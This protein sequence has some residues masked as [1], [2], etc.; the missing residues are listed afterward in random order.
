MK[1]IDEFILANPASLFVL[2]LIVGFFLRGLM[3]SVF[4]ASRTKKPGRYRGRKSNMDVNKPS[5]T[6]VDIKEPALEWSDNVVRNIAQRSSRYTNELNQSA[7]NLQKVA[8]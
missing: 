4:S 5:A 7:K 2:G 8:E 1:F 3:G 6:V